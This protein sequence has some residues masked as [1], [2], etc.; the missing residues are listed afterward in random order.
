MMKNKQK[1]HK[2]VAKRFRMTASG[3]FKKRSVHRGHNHTVNSTGKK[4]GLRTN[5]AVAKVD[6]PALKKM[7]CVKG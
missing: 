1:T 5:T 2:G 7:L 6:V 4:R 3:G